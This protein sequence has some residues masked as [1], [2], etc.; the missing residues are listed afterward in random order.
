MMTMPPSS[1]AGKQVRDAL[2]V[3]DLEAHIR[4]LIAVEPMADTPLIS[5]YTNRDASLEASSGSAASPFAERVVTLR[6]SI[7]GPQ[8]VMVDEALARVHEYVAH[9]LRPETKGVA[10][11]ARGGPKPFFLPLQFHVYLPEWIVADSI[12]NLYH[13]VELKDTYHRF[14]LLLMTEASARI[15]EINL[16]AVT[17]EVWAQRPELRNRVSSGWTKSH[18]QHH[19]HERTGRFVADEIKILD[20]LLGAGGYTHLILAGDPRMTARMRAALPPH[21][22]AKLVDT[23]HASARDTMRDIVAAT[24][25]LF[26]EHEQGESLARVRLLERELKVH[27]LAAVGAGASLQA[28]RRGQVDVLILAKEYSAVAPWY[29]DACGAIGTSASR[30]PDCPECGGLPRP[31]VALREE[32]VRQA[33]RNAAEIEIVHQSDFLMELGGVG[34]LLRYRA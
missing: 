29:C 20:R 10:V 25:S 27:G 16:G 31:D 26:A 21:L 23:V 2:A 6:Q 8:R 7:R 9:H 17:T 34:C 28:L 4:A 18:Y 32:L 22:S 12:P 33:E 5:C 15:L 24:N 13:L 1:R 30:H 19:R 11:F 3:A 14:V